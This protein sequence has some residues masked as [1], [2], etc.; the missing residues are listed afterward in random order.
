MKYVKTFENFS[1]PTFEDHRNPLVELDFSKDADWS[2]S[3]QLLDL[4]DDGK[5]EDEWGY[6]FSIPGIRLPGDLFDLD[7]SATEE[8]KKVKKEKILKIL[9]Y[10]GFNTEDD[11]I[12]NSKLI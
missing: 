11:K 1:A 7:K 12:K 10:F 2:I 9:Q 8:Q 5:L 4:Y 6:N 3:T